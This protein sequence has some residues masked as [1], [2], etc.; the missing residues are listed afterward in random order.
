M[1]A[2]CHLA[3]LLAVG[4][5][6]QVRDLV[7]VAWS[8]VVVAD[9]GDAVVIDA[10]PRT[11]FEAGHIPGSVPLHWTELTE[12]DADGLWDARP[13]R[14]LGALLDRRGV[15]L[16]QPVVV[17]GSGPL[18][19]GDDGNVYWTLRWLG[20]PDVSVLS[21]GYLGW[22]ATGGEPETGRAIG[23]GEDDDWTDHL[24]AGSGP[25]DPYYATS[26][27]V[28]AWPGTVL[29]VRSDQEFATGHIP[30]ATW[31]EWTAAFDGELLAPEDVVRARLR[32]AGVELDAPVVTT[33]RSGI[34][35]GHTF[36]VLDALGVA[37]P[38][39]YVG[40]WRRWTAEGRPV[41]R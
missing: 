17:V 15:P 9:V 26:A 41:E 34:R 27:D 18:G 10:R 14:D 6:P 13:P 37:D 38:A 3:A 23:G 11:V 39:N 22:L 5:G 16:H 19:D 36:M 33:C 20:H 24:A 8:R 32:A 29:D 21:G 2:R 1:T 35:A 25:D 40:S 12:L 7:P 30:G 31:M 4:C 28:A